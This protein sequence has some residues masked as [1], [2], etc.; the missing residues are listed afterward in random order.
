MKRITI[1][2]ALL[3]A[4]T[5]V[6]QA[7]ISYTAV[8]KAQ[9]G[10]A[11]DAQGGTI[12][13]LA[14]GLKARV[15]FVEGSNPMARPGSYIVTKDGGKLVMLVNPD[16]KT[17]MRWDV[18][19]FSA[20]A[21]DMMKAVGGFVNVTVKDHSVKKLLDEPGPTLHGYPTRHVKVQTAYTIQTSVMGMVQ[22]QRHSRIDEIW[23]TRKLDEP[24]LTLWANQQRI[25]TGNE[26]LDKLIESEIAQIDGFPL[27]RITQSSVTNRGRTQTDS[28]TFEV[29][30]LD[31]VRPPAGAFEVPA[32]YTEQKMELPADMAM[33]DAEDDGDA[34]ERS[35]PNS[36]GNPVDSLRK[37]FGRG[38]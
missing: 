17:Y 4:A 1:G 13:G 18:E 22:S 38:R 37:L 21:G 27:K 9:G 29:T 33:P 12:K 25:R 30:A 26:S 31:K 3:A 16:E 7:G 32:G 23:A 5:A 6:G 8:T 35:Q 20:A 10:P 19:K 34:D 15:E 24:G 14:D 11:A 28:V 36:G 2:L